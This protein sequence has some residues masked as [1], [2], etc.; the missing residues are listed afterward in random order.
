[1]LIFVLLYMFMF[2]CFFNL[3]FFSLADFFFIYIYCVLYVLIHQSYCCLAKRNLCL[4]PNT[5]FHL[6]QLVMC[7]VLLHLTFSHLDRFV[8]SFV[9]LFSY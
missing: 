9:L 1:M 5:M 7:M 2:V 8:L 4:I 3:P 6:I